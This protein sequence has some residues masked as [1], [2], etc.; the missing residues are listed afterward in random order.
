MSYRTMIQ[1]SITILLIDSGSFFQ[2]YLN[3]FNSNRL[4]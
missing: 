4:L 1:D 3:S 2:V